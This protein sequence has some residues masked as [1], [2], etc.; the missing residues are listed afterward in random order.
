VATTLTGPEAAAVLEVDVP[1][2]PVVDVVVPVV[3]DVV[4][5][6]GGLVVVDDEDDDPHAVRVPA[7]ATAANSVIAREG[8]MS[9]SCSSARSDG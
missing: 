9:H 2:T 6:D 4:V 1:G 7:R 8:A 5:A 3:V